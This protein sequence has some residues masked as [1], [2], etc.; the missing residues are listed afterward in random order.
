VSVSSFFNE[1]TE[2]SKVKTEIVAKYFVAW[3][4]VVIASTKQRD[5]KIGYVDL[6]AGPGR[7]QDGTKS[8]PLLIL[9]EAIKEPNLR[10][11]IV[12]AFSDADPENVQSLK[13]AINTLPNINTLKNKPQV[14]TEIVND[15][16]A[17][18]FNSIKLIPSLTFLDPWGYKGLSTQLINSV[19][20][21]WGCDCIVFFNYNRINMGL[22][23]DLVKEHMNALFGIER[24]ATLRT[25][26]TSSVT[27]PERERKIL[28]AL[29][30]SLKDLGGDFVLPFRFRGEQ[31]ERIS[32]HLVFVTKHI[33]GYNIMKDIMANASSNHYQGVPSFEYSPIEEIQPHLFLP[34]SPIDYLKR[35][36]SHIFAGKSISVIE[37]YNKHNVGTN[38]IKKNYKQAL[39]QLEQE[40]KVLTNPT[41]DKRKK[42]TLADIVQVT[43]PSKEI[44]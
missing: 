40:G 16:V 28:K 17:V 27:P 19:I 34:D 35:D 25:E 41:Y 13:N 21:D 11:M 44:R 30:D 23:N 42:N 4:K 2:Q 18:I 10:K 1:S 15:K 29:S 22:G 24:A 32:H 12:T 8:T 7:Y 14:Y 5:G 43:F 26:L 39:M 38:Y 31:G 33:K 6:F 37:L 9:E 3:A 20:K 36:I